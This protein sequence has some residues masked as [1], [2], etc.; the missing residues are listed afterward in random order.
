MRTLVKAPDLHRCDFMIYAAATA[1]VFKYN[2]EDYKNQKY[3]TID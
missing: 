3:R 2:L 1:L